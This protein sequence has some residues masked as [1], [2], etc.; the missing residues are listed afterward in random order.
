VASALQG[1]LD[2]VRLPIQLVRP[3]PGRLAWQ[4]DLEAARELH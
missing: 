4:I 2:P 1:P 3:G